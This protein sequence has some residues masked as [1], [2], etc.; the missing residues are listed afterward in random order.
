MPKRRFLDAKMQ[1]FSHLQFDTI[2]YFRGN[3]VE[4]RFI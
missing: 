3:R 4:I 2:I 1:D